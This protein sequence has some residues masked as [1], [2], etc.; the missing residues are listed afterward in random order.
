[1]ANGVLG[2]GRVS[3]ALAPCSRSTTDDTDFE[4]GLGQLPPLEHEAQPAGN[5]YQGQAAS[6][7][8]AS[9]AADGAIHS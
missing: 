6:M 4:D 5:L 9:V 2:H 8:M 7:C 3:N 1:M